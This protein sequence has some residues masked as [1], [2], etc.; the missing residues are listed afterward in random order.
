MNDATTIEAPAESSA[1]QRLQAAY[2]ELGDQATASQIAAKA[3]I[4]LELADEFVDELIDADAEQSDGAVPRGEEVGVWADGG[5]MYMAR[6]GEPTDKL[7]RPLAPDLIAVFEDAAEFRALII[8]LGRCKSALRNLA[9]RRSAV[10]LDAVAA[11]GFLDEV[12]L[13]LESTAPHCVCPSCS[14]QKRHGLARRKP[15][16]TCRGL[17]FIC[18][19]DFARLNADLQSI[20]GAYRRAD[21]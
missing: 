4:N 3:G 18:A 20:A 9:E 6:P 8:A 16:P 12:Q 14:G 10:E 11:I 2:D 5:P 17:G 1:R 19:G 13:H 15:C 7:G 21:E